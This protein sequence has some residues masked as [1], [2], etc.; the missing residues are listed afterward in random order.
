[1]GTE[2]DRDS[3]IDIYNLHMEYQKQASLYSKWGGRKSKAVK[4][5][6]LI[7]EE[8]KVLKGECK[9]VIEEKRAEIDIL[10]RTNHTY[11]VFYKDQKKKYPDYEEILDN[12]Q[13]SCEKKIT[14]A[15]VNS[16]VTLHPEYIQIQKEM[17]EKINQKTLE[18]S[19]V[20]ESLGLFD[21][22]VMAMIHRKA[23]IEGEISLWL[24]EYYSDPKIPKTYIEQGQKKVQKKLRKRLGG[25][26]ST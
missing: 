3:K 14:E 5:E 18:L 2:L 22:A 17:N 15:M 21:T 6:F 24:G 12:F 10:F 20:I 25:R 11:A 26:N 9:R 7:R 16:F 1:M 23:A 19:K 4:E 8:L 13:E